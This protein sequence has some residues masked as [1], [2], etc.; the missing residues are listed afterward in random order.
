MRTIAPQIL[1]SR[2]LFPSIAV[3]HSARPTE[4]PHR[5][6]H[7]I[8]S[9]A[10]GSLQPKYSTQAEPEGSRASRTIGNV[11]HRKWAMAANLPGKWPVGAKETGIPAGRETDFAAFPNRTL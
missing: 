9:G 10:V 4:T 6:R 11:Y 1:C 2:Y 7:Q 8:A 5:L 3:A